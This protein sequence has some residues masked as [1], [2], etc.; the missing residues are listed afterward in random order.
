MGL[1]WQKW[2]LPFI[3]GGLIGSALIL[4]RFY[5]VESWA[6]P[7]IL[8]HIESQSLGIAEIFVQIT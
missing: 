1:I 2:L 3:M 7:Q 6:W 8:T 4:Q 5:G